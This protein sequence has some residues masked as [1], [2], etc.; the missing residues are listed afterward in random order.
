M[1]SLMGHTKLTLKFNAGSVCMHEYETKIK[2]G[3]II[4]YSAL[5]GMDT[6]GTMY[7]QSVVPS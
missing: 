3:H 4:Y 5:V 2:D 6:A 1:S 7:T